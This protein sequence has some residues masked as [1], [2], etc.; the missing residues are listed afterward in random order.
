MGALGNREASQP[1]LGSLNADTGLTGAGYLATPVSAGKG[2]PQ[3][4]WILFWFA[5]IAALQSLNW[6]TYSSVPDHSKIFL[7][8]TGDGTCVC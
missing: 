1:L 5:Y 3:R 2:E 7:N 8:I 4:W 6:M